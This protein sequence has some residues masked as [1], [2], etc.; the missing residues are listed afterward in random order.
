M[1]SIS[2]D[3]TM[4]IMVRKTMVDKTLHRK[5]TIEQHETHNQQEKR[6]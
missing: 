5:I 2:D 3:V 6:K 1:I 4:I